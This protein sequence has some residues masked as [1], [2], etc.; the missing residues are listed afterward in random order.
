MWVLSNSSPVVNAHHLLGH[1][2]RTNMHLLID[3]SL[4]M[5]FVEAAILSRIAPGYGAKRFSSRHVACSV[6]TETRQECSAVC[7]LFVLA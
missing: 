4:A 6:H 2:T 3:I 7:Y 1:I 5:P